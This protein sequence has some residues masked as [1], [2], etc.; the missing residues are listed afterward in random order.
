MREL[1]PA[2]LH[3]QVLEGIESKLDGKMSDSQKLLQI[4]NNKKNLQITSKMIHMGWKTVAEELKVGLQ[5]SIHSCIY[6]I[7]L[8]ISF[9]LYLF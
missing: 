3:P 1:S 2:L 5:I 7:S 8:S 6:F 4:C 9:F